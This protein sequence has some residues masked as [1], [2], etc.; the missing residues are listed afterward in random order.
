VNR[1]R[2]TKPA[3]VSPPAAEATRAPERRRLTRAQSIPGT[4]CLRGHTTTG[5]AFEITIGTAYFRDEMVGVL[6]QLLEL[7]EPARPAL[8]LVR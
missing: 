3:A 5:V 7:A 8:E 6:E 1:R 4:C 2:I